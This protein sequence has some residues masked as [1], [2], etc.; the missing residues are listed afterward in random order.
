M[1]AMKASNA[2]WQL[3][4]IFGD[5]IPSITDTT[6]LS[7]SLSIPLA[8]SL[9]L[10]LSPTGV[11]ATTIT[12]DYD[13]DFFFFDLTQNNTPSEGHAEPHTQAHTYRA[14]N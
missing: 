11:E 7:L 13:Y 12:Y 9:S 4:T 5:E 1:M 3:H 2:K 10:S 8:R 14:A 6:P